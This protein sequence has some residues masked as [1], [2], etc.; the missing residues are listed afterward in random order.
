[1]NWSASWSLG[2]GQGPSFV[3]G[4]SNVALAL[5]PAAPGGPT[6][7]V[8]NFTTN[9]VTA[10]ADA[11]NAAYDLSLHVTDNGTHDSG[12]LTFHGLINGTT[13]PDGQ[14]LKNTFSNPSQTLSLDGHAY[15]VSLDP[16]TVIPDT[17][18]AAVALAARVSVDSGTTT[19]GPPP[20][21]VTHGPATVP[22]APEPSALLLAGLGLAGASWMRQRRARRAE[23]CG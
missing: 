23:P 4:L 11:F 16:N 17:N 12:L 9:S 22:Q 20:V 15:H 1:M 19:G 7:A 21:T 8:G 3:S 13:G 2:Q 10:E 5:S 14:G 18:H 6:L